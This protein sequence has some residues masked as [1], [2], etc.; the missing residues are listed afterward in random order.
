LRRA[1]RDAGARTNAETARRTLGAQL[2]PEERDAIASPAGPPA[3]WL[4]VSETAWAGL[5]AWYMVALIG[6][7]GVAIRRA[8]AVAAGL[9]A[10]ILFAAAVVGILVGVSRA[11]AP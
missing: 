5:A 9:A 10:V 4:S 3:S 2:Q 6:A 11:R 7:V 8:R 1:P